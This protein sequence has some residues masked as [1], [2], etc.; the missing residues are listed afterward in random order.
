MK[1]YDR[2][3]EWHTKIPS[4]LAGFGKMHIKIIL[5]CHRLTGG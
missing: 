5:E 3:I 4:F 2:M 1:D